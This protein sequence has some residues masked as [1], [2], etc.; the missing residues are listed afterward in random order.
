LVLVGIGQNGKG[1]F[2]LILERMVGT[3]SV[4]AINPA[5]FSERFSLAGL[6]GK[7]VNVCGDMDIGSLNEGILK[8]LTGQDLITVDRK[9]KELLS[10]KP[11]A[12]QVFS[13]NNLPKI[14]DKSQGL[15]R[16]ICILPCNA[17]VAGD[18]VKPNL[19]EELASEMSAIFN[20]AVE[21][22]RRLLRQGRFTESA[23][24]KAAETA[25]RN[26]NDPI[27]H[28][29]A[30]RCEITPAGSILT[31]DLFQAYKTWAEDHGHVACSNSD[32]GRHVLRFGGI[33]RQKRSATVNPQRPW[34]YRGIRLRSE[35]CEEVDAADAA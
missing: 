6:R 4:A 21:G 7:L 1:V 31:A 27:G 28:F 11:T 25:Y 22:Y 32:F 20:W 18:A 19:V 29:I 33:K 2:L 35:T 24:G 8:Q 14:F 26:A 30:Q 10:F 34:E 13:T 15:W 9:H 23:A 17:V 16:R 5:A 12:K 3:S